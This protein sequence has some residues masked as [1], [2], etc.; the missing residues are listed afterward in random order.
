MRFGDHIVTD[1]L[2]R[3]QC[4]KDEALH[5]EG[6][7]ADLH[8]GITVKAYWDEGTETEPACYCLSWHKGLMPP[9]RI[10]TFE[11]ADQLR[12]AMREL[13][14]TDDDTYIAGL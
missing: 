3:D 11:T 5:G 4:A 9:F 6:L 12:G 7:C 13:G 2:Y 8:N 1:A 14:I 10:D